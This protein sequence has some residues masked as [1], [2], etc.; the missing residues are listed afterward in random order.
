MICINGYHPRVFIIQPRKV[1]CDLLGV[2]LAAVHANKGRGDVGLLVE[3]GET[4][5][6]EVR[7]L[8][9][10]CGLIFGAEAGG[11]VVGGLGAG[12]VNAVNKGGDGGGVNF[13]GGGSGVVESAGE[14]VLGSTG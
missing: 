11:E 5:A 13:R 9:D 2:C 3:V 1:A 4:K 6:G 8:V 12:A 10:D 7:E 14:V